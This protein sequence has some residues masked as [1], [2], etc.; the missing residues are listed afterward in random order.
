MATP[1]YD[2]LKGKVRDWSA[3]PEANTIPDTVIASCLSYAAD[4]CYQILRIPPLE[5]TITYAVE[6][7]DNSTTEDHTS[8]NI[9]SDLIEFAYLRELPQ[10]NG[11]SAVFNEITDKRTFYD[12]Y[13][14]KYNTY[15]WMW[16]DDKIFVHPQLEVGTTLEIN[17]YRRLPALDA[18]YSAVAVN[19]LTGLS[20][21][22]QPYLT[23]GIGSDT[24]L[25]FAGVGA[26]KQV[27]E[28][29]ADA[30]AYG[31]TQ[32]ITTVTTQYYVG[33]EVPHW[34]RDENERMLIWGALFNLGAYLFDDIME[35]RYE[36]KFKENLADINSEEKRR[37]ARGGN[38]R[39]NFNTGGLI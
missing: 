2:I 33:K 26:A 37:R 22:D 1:L 36:K 35:K 25:Y 34:L 28:I 23:V 13:S 17:Y 32:P 10:S 39:M 30:T 11:R 16:Q 8:F 9:P 38:V 15:N 24:P 7:A 31:L 4:D 20:D 19:Y 29:L 18:L 12:A 5:R 3:K 6:L 21:G 14:E 27:F